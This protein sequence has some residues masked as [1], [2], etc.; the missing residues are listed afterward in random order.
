M[1][2]DHSIYT[3]IDTFLHIAIIFKQREKRMIQNDSILNSNDFILKLRSE[4]ERNEEKKYR[5]ILFH[6]ISVEDG[7]WKKGIS[8]EFSFVLKRNF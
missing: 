3:Y 4:K 2:C 7:R 8:L 5:L 6:L 1:S